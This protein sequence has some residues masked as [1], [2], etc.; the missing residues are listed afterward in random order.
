MYLD[1]GRAVS[2]PGDVCSPGISWQCWT[3]YFIWGPKRCQCKW[4]KPSLGWKAIINLSQRAKT[5]TEATTWYVLKNKE[6]PFRLS[7]TK[8]SWKTTEV[9]QSG[10][11]TELQTTQEHWGRQVSPC[12]DLQSRDVSIQTVYDK[13]QI[14]GYTEGL[15]DLIRLQQK[16]SKRAHT[17]LGKQIIWTDE[18]K[19]N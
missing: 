13:V 6:I 18:T 2:L 10:M 15:D 4:G 5:S 12:Q 1:K 9:K 16:T 8:N 11:M 17:V 3:L 14:T 7:N 19:M